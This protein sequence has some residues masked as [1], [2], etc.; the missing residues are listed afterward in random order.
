MSNILIINQPLNHR[1]FQFIKSELTAIK[2]VWA[3][4]AAGEVRAIISS[5]CKQ[6]CWVMGSEHLIIR[7]NT[8]TE[9][10]ESESEYDI[11]SKL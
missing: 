6:S 7:S 9:E 5:V 4:I 10:R 11:E 3:V 1:N 2:E 8:G